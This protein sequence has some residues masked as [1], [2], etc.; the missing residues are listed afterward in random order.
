MHLIWWDM[1]FLYK[2]LQP[3]GEQ[4]KWKDWARWVTRATV[5]VGLG[6]EHI[7]TAGNENTVTNVI[8][9]TAAVRFF[10]RTVDV[11][12]REDL[13]TSCRQYLMN[14][15]QRT[16]QVRSQDHDIDLDVGVLRLS[17]SS[18]QVAGW[19]A[20]ATAMPF[21]VGRVLRMGWSRMAAKGAICSQWDSDVQLLSEVMYVLTHVFRER[22]AKREHLLKACTARPCHNL[23]DVLLHWL[24]EGIDR[25][26][27]QVYS[28]VH[29][30]SRP[31]P[32]LKSTQSTYTRVH[33][34]VIWTIFEGARRS[35]TSVEQVIEIRKNDQHLS[36]CASQGDAW[37]NKAQNMYKDGFSLCLP[38]VREARCCC[39]IG[40]LSY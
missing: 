18:G 20:I 30:T 13:T 19:H 10:A 6:G 21:T 29:D 28:T 2:A 34:E 33:P 9:S 26:I 36:C 24:I 5:E 23:R 3:A 22:R 14:S 40:L 12:R 16:M 39:R 11:G 17:P 37:M 1:R 7:I 15:L 35:S 8:T 32:A 38:S 31:A 4:R 27:L 25:Y